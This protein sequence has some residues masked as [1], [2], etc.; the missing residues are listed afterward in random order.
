MVNLVYFAQV[1]F[2]FKLSSGLYVRVVKL[3]CDL[4]SVAI[5]VYND[6]NNSNNNNEMILNFVHF[7]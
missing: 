6:N 5:L 2:I 3:L 7:C 4:C 1:V